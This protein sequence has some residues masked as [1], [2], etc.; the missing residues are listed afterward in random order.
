ML[1]RGFTKCL[2]SLLFIII[3]AGIKAQTG[4]FKVE[5][6]FLGTP[7]QLSFYVPSNYDNTK[8][9][10][11]F[12]GLHGLGDNSENYRNAIINTLR[13]DTVFKNTI[14][15]FPEAYHVN[16]DYFMPEGHEEIINESIKY[17]GSKYNINEKNIILQ[18]FSLGGR[19]ALRFGLQNPEKFRGVLLNNPAVQGIKETGNRSATGYNFNYANAP[20]IPVYIVIGRQDVLYTNIADSVF[21]QLVKHNGRVHLHEFETMAHTIPQAG[22][23]TNVLSFFDNPAHRSL[24]FNLLQITAPKYTC[25][26]TTAAKVL[27]RN[28]GKTNITS[29]EFAA[30]D[31]TLTKFYNWTGNLKPFE[32]AE[33][34]IT[35]IPTTEGNNQ[36][37]VNV[38]K[39]NGQAH[40]SISAVSNKTAAYIRTAKGRALPYSENFEGQVFPPAGWSINGTGE[41]YAEW[42]HS[43]NADK[44]FGA[45]FAINTILIFDNLG[46]REELISPTLDLTT[47]PKPNLRFN[48]AYNYHK[49]TP[50]Y[51]AEDTVF[52]DTLEVL[53]STNCGSTFKSIYKKGGK[54]LA[55]FAKP[56]ANITSLNGLMNTP[57]DTNWR[58]EA[59]DLSDFAASNNAMIK[60]SYKSALGG[61]I[62]LDNVLIG[63]N[64]LS[65]TEKQPDDFAIYPNP[66]NGIVNIKSNGEAVKAVEIADVSGRIVLTHN[67]ITSQQQLQLNTS[68][69]KPGLYFV[70]LIKPDKSETAKLLISR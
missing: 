70:R 57:R 13:F 20:E 66:A 64:S 11:L 48:V 32:H 46:S 58:Y 35:N 69:L 24:D 59:L 41:V 43:S 3:S 4:S 5:I 23:L 54:D 17:A 26:S 18:G 60:F 63:N 38:S 9:Y 49:Y 40:D 50:P 39:I 22:R 42:D 28:T 12:I 1:L 21:I 52:A 6:D 14:F 33:F 51:V 29:V 34:T 61:I 65:I 44:K 2:L 15:V 62:Y 27:F 19:A 36:L 68:A 37:N 53:V 47:L 56:M 45:A 25:N 16:A 10:G 8:Q 67:N 30:G 55:S 31:G 7:R